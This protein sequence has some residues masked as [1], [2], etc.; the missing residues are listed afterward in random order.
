MAEKNANA[1]RDG[2]KVIAT[3]RKARHEY[4]ILDTYEAG[5]SLLGS[6][7]KSLRDGKA[8]FKDSY[9]SANI[10]GVILQNLHIAPYDKTGFSGH[11]SERPRRLLLHEREI[12]RL[13]SQAQEKGLTIIPLRLYFKGK[14]AKVEIALCRG[15]RLYDKR[16]AIIERETRRNIEREFKRRR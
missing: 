1:R 6:E 10:D 4:E 13:A 5:M 11:D 2:I 9:A 3:N 15:K 7:V 12:R 8:S 16:A 14:H